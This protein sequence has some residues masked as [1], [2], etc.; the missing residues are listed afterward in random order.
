MGVLETRVREENRE[1]VWAKLNLGH[2]KLEH[3]YLM[4]SQ[5][6]IWVM[7]DA[8]VVTLMVV[9]KSSQYIHCKV[10]WG[11]V[12]FFWTCVY[13]SY[14]FGERRE[15]WRDL[16]RIGSMLRDPWLIQ[17]DFN[18]IYSNDDRMGG[19]PANKEATNEFQNWI[20]GLYL[21]EV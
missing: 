20:L 10:T 4:S 2:W 12:I 18:A 7:Y 9:G 16:T 19:V 14:D 8:K 17:G 21:V 15:L 3:N 5:G 1:D 11:E 13:G 6:R